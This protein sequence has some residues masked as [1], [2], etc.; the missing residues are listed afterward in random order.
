MNRRRFL[1]QTCA[2]G[3]AGLPLAALPA[4]AAPGRPRA[5]G[6]TLLVGANGRPLRASRLKP[7]VN[8]LFHY[9]Y[10]ATPVFLLD[11]GKAL[12]G[13]SLSTGERS[14]VYHWPGGSGR[15]HSVVAYSAICPYR[16]VYPSAEVSLISYRPD[17]A[18]RGVQ[19][20]LIHCCTDHCQFD[21]AQGA[22]VLAGPAQQPLVGV[23]L[24]HDPASDTLTAYA[25]LGAELFDEFFDKFSGQLQARYGAGWRARVSGPA[26]VWELSAYSRN[27][28]RC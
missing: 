16:L 21:P 27:S 14:T 18:L 9:P 19:N 11:L 4:M 17:R 5:Y 25:T 10:A 8:Y 3:A 15:R 26:R 28:V 7:H 22:A 2:A 12:A 6:Q 1:E 20:G 24:S 23:M 13:H